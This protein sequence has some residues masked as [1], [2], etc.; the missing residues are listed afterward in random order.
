V[1]QAPAAPSYAASPVPS[2]T[3]AEE[4]SLKLILRAAQKTAEQTIT[5]A[6]ARAEEILSE[7]RYRASEITRDSDRKAFEAASRVQSELAQ[8]EDQLKQHR[9]EVDTMAR[10]VETEKGRVRGFAY[11][12]LRTVGDEPT[13]VGAGAPSRPLSA[14]PVPLDPPPAP[15]DAVVLDLTN[16]AE[17]TPA[18]QGGGGFRNDFDSFSPFGT[19]S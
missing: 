6:R 2:S 4:E 9:A 1:A 13:A 16:E 19:D 18:K 15:A 8:M 12:L 17:P 5:D 3:E 14:P 11:D 7:A 10:T